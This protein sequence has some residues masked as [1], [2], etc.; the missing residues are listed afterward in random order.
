MKNKLEDKLF[1]EI[2][3]DP[4]AIIKWCEAEIKTYKELIKLV[5]E[6]RSDKR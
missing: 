2:K 5:K 1:E 3:N 4:D 6:K